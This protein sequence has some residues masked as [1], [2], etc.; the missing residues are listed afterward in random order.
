MNRDLH[1]LAQRACIHTVNPFPSR[2][3]HPSLPPA[4]A[5]PLSH[6][7]CHWF[8]DLWQS[9]ALARA[10]EAEARAARAEA[11]LARSQAGATSD[12]QV[13]AGATLLISNMLSLRGKPPPWMSRPHLPP[14]PI[15]VLYCFPVAWLSKFPS[16]PSD[17]SLLGP[18]LPRL[19]QNPCSPSRA[20]WTPPHH[21]SLVVPD[22]FPLRSAFSLLHAL[23]P[24]S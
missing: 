12:I 16:F 13:R 5:T 3:N 10:L 19:A 14:R 2:A 24:V 9:E 22:V 21:H 23:I 1:L 15:R 18:S 4:S 7:S 17:A 11:A 20:H 6:I 8:S